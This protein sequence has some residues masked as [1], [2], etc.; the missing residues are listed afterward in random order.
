MKFGVKC[1]VNVKKLD[2]GYVYVVSFTSSSLED[3]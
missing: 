1:E 3:Y 2:K